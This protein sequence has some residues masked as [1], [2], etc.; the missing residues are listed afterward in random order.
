MRSYVLS[1]GTPPLGLKYT[2]SQKPCHSDN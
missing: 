2:P 1:Q